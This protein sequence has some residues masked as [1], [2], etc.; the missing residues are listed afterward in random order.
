MPHPTARLEEESVLSAIPHANGITTQ[1]TLYW[2]DLFMS[3]SCL[4]ALGFLRAWIPSYF[5]YYL[6]PPNKILPFTYSTFHERGLARHYVANSLFLPFTWYLK[7]QQMYKV[8]MVIVCTHKKSQQSFPSLNQFLH[9]L[10]LGIWLVLANKMQWKWCL[11][12]SK[13]RLQGA[14]STSIL[15]R[16]S[17]TATGTG[18][19]RWKMRGHMEH[20]WAK[21][22][23]AIL[24]QPAPRPSCGWPQ[25]H[26]P[27]SHQSHLAQIRDTTSHTQSL[28]W[29]SGCCFKPLK[30]W[31]H[32]LHSNN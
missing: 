6:L 7:W 14:L 31:S 27:I 15:L 26:E 19:A 29:I 24:D 28:S 1:T 9:C 22:A 25:M 30:F 16:P 3:L 5:Y 32:L 8:R 10:N 21:P 2:D 17:A 23:E 18:P 12:S 11:P 13:P 20:G 4:L